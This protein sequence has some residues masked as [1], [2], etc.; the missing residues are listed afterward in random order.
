M[1]MNIAVHY[2]RRKQVIYV[3]DTLQAVIREVIDTEDLDL[4]ADPSLVR[5]LYLFQ[6][7]WLTVR[8]FIAPESTLKNSN[9]E[10]QAASAKIYR[11]ARP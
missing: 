1:Y 5:T 10:S 4:E 3:R 11:F 2:V 9:Q 7:V 8:R 6:L